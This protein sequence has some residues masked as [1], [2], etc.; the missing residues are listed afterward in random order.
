LKNPTLEFKIDGPFSVGKTKLL[1][2]LEEISA[3]ELSINTIYLTYESILANKIDE[4]WDESNCKIDLVN[5]QNILDSISNID[6]GIAIFSDKTKVQIIIPPIP[7]PKDVIS[8]GADVTELIELIQSD[9]SIGV[10]LVRLGHY[11]IGIL[12]NGTLVDS[13][14]G[15]RYVKRSHRAGGSSQ[16]RFER[17]RERLIKEMLDKTCE[18]TMNLFDNFGKNIN[19]LFM[20]GEKHTLQRFSKTC[21]YLSKLDTIKLDR[22]LKVE[23]PSRKTLMQIH[24][25]V[26]NSRVITIHHAG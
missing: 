22:V 24:R 1:G 10:I 15:S 19:Y 9:I 14:T 5:L 7:I 26:W 6:T 8:I 17:S 12:E 25:Q 11:A 18:E 3:S 16:R 4:I 13:K 20:G 21:K 2:L 23:R